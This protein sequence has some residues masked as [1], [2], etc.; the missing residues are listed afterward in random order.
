MAYNL[1]CTVSKVVDG[2]VN[3]PTAS[4]ITSNGRM[5]VSDGNSITVSTS[6]DGMSAMSTLTFDPLRTSNNGAYMCVGSLSSPALQTPLM[7]SV[8][9]ELSVQSNVT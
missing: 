3:S 6:S 9:E 5:P 8:E 7:S 4:W 2:L 1:T